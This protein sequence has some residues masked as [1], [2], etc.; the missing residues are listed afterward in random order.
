MQ[1]EKHQCEE[2]LYRQAL[3][4]LDTFTP[5]CNVY[6][7]LVDSP[8]MLIRRRKNHARRTRKSNDEKENANGNPDSG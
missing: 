4:R 3:K 8:A 1:S 6:K 5:S 7:S 2:S